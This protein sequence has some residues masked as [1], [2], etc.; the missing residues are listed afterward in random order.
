MIDA[1]RTIALIGQEAYQRIRLTRVLLFGV[2]GVGGWCAEAL[3]RS[4]IQHLTIVDYDT[5]AP[6]NL[7]R[8]IVATS[9]NIGL[10]KVTE[11][12][13]RLITIE[14][15]LDIQAIEARYPFEVDWS[16]YDIVIDAI[17]EI[18]AK[19]QLLHN[20]TEAG[21]QVFCSLGAG[22]RTDTQHIHIGEWKKVS[23]CPLA[24]ALRHKM[25]ETLL[26]PKGPVQ[27]VWSDA[28]IEAEKGTI[29]PVVGIFGLQ[30]AS[31]VLSVGI[32]H[33]R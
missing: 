11:M 4:G 26:F 33:K 22:R 2:G 1:Q 9:E 31:L 15:D 29:A 14:P 5:V 23:G 18:G 30:L 25:K 20:A 17:D 10:S 3:V 27:C 21:K 19:V 13:K 12:A 8:Q 6:S 32:L 28:D 7:N 24:R 16:Q